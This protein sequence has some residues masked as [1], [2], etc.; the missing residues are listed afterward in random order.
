MTV[1]HW[2]WTMASSTGPTLVS[3]LLQIV[4]INIGSANRHFKY[5]SEIFIT[6]TEVIGE[7]VEPDA[8]ACTV[9][10]YSFIIFPQ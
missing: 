8:F 9:W 7:R 4:F 2:Q 5:W 10:Y 6:L 3:N 1:S